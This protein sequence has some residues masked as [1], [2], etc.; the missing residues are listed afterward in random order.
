M[1]RAAV[2]LSVRVDMKN[3]KKEIMWRGVARWI[4][5]V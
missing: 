5:W 4:R 1:A 2:Q 3:G